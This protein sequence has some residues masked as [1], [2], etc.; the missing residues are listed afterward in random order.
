V[1]DGWWATEEEDIER[2][3]D[4]LRDGTGLW[5]GELASRGS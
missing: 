4:G 2:R 1:K 3:R 5:S